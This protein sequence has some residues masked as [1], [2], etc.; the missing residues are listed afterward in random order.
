M[1]RLVSLSRRSPDS[2][3]SGKKTEKP[4]PKPKVEYSPKGVKARK[5]KIEQNL[6]EKYHAQH[7]IKE[8]MKEKSKFQ[9]EKKPKNPI[10]EKEPVD[11]MAELR[12]E[13]HKD[14]K[15]MKSDLRVNNTKIDDLNLKINEIESKTNIN[16]EFNHQISEQSEMI[17][18]TLRLM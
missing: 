6:R 7:N 2:K 5:A 13:I 15:E 11:P 8:I 14:I 10:R 12:K 16:E 17:C 3:S 1:G 9:K 18:S 4:S